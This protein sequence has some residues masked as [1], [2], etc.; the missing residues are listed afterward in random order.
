MNRLCTEDSFLAPASYLRMFLSTAFLSY[1]PKAQNTSGVNKQPED[2]RVEEICT[3]S[4]AS[5]VGDH[6]TFMTGDKADEKQS[7]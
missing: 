1:L 5:P 4:L 3:D 6:A 7:S 2:D